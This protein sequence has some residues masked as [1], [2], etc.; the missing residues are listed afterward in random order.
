MAQDPKQ[1]QTEPA[2]QEPAPTSQT[3]ATEELSDEQLDSVAGGF[4]AIKFEYE[5]GTE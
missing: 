4:G 2:Q 1:Q 3:A 5:P